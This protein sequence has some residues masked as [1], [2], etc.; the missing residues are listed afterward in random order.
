[1]KA[2]AKVTDHRNRAP[3]H[4]GATNIEYEGAFPALFI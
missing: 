3:I 4:D 2:F 1:M